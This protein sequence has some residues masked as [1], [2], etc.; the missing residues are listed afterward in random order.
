MYLTKYILN[1][2]MNK[3]GLKRFIEELRGDEAKEVFSILHDL[4]HYS[5]NL[6]Y[7]FYSLIPS[8]YKWPVEKTRMGLPRLIKKMKGVKINLPKP[9][10][11]LLSISLAETLERRR[12]IRRFKK[13]S[14]SLEE[15]STLLYYSLGVKGSSW[16]I[17]LRMFPSAGALQPIEAY[18]QVNKVDGLNPG[19]YHYE[20]DEHILILL[21][22][23]DFKREMYLYTLQQD[24]VRDASINI[25]LTLVL[26]RTQSKYGYRA[27]RYAL[28]DTG[29][30]GMNIYLVSTSMGLGTCAVGAYYDRDIDRLLDLDGVSETSMIIYPVGKP[31]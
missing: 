17:P 8:K 12:S 5:P 30:V 25:I 27:Y 31:K 14:L 20:P 28:L 13:E 21:K 7:H 19:I 22:K 9:N 15:V 11:N 16:G 29:H 2:I 6:L 4:T 1:I 3:D 26:S 10:P 24:H 23:G 18:L